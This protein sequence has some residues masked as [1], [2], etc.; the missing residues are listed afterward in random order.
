MIEII[1][2][3][4]RKVYFICS[5]C[6][7]VYADALSWANAHKDQVAKTPEEAENI[8]I[9]SC[10]VTDLAILSDFRIAERMVATYPS[11]NIFI[12]GCL[13]ER[14]DIPMPEGVRRLA[15]MRTNY[16]PIEDKSLVHWEKPFWVP[17][18][19]DTGSETR[20]GGLFRNSYPLRIGKGCPFNCT[21]C[22]IKVTRGPHE[23]YDIDDRLRA[24]FLS[25]DNVVLIADSPQADQIKAWCQLAIDTKK[26]IS[27]RNIEPQVAVKCYE[28]LLKVARA[29]L[30]K[31]FHCAIQSNDPEVLNDMGRNVMTTMLAIEIAKSL[32]KYGVIIATN[33]ILDY[34]GY[35][36]DGVSIVGLYETYD[37]I[38]WNPLWDGKWDRETAEKRWKKYI[39]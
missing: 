27:I 4:K 22:T 1:E 34:K 23:E 16:Q 32:K 33:I 6:M 21:F 24:E 11:K 10:Q 38:S 39:E 14:Q 20:P 8:I 2:S 9:L 28:D 5:A 26:S 31:I 12:S 36:T 17:E 3:L 13:A 35:Q 19:K 15:Q 30:L 25:H 18:F 29:G 37:H 7:T